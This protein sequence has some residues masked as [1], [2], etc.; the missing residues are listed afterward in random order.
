MKILWWLINNYFNAAINNESI[1]ITK[2]NCYKEAFFTK[3]IQ[4]WFIVDY[5]VQ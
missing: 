3:N 2:Y 4:E 5:E 1:L